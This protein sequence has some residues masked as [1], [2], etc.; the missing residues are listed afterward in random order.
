MAFRPL[1][2]GVTVNQQAESPVIPVETPKKTS[3][4]DTVLGAG[5][6]VGDFFTSS[7]QGLGKNIADIATAPQ[8]QSDAMRVAAADTSFLS[9]LI[10]LRRKASTEGK[11]TSHYDKLIADIHSDGYKAPDLPSA[12][13]VG[14]NAAGT[15]ADILSAGTYGAA[16]TAAM[17]TGELATKAVPTAVSLAEQGVKAGVD[18]AKSVG[19]TI[20][21]NNAK[22]GA[23]KVVEVLAL[24][25]ENMTLAQKKEAIDAGRQVV[26]NVAGGQKVT[27]A[28][29]PE[30]ERAGEILTDPK[31]WVNPVTAK[32]APH[33]IYAKVKAAIATLGSRAETYLAKNPVPIT[34]KEDFDLFRGLRDIA[35]KSSTD[36]ELK[37]YDEQI[38]LFEKQLVGR[39]GYNTSNYY[40][41]LKDWEQN[42]ASKLPRGK[43]ALL[44]P[45]GIA[46]A[47]IQ[48]ASDIRKAVRDLIASKH[49]EFKSR[50]YDLASLFEAKDS[51]LIN[52]AKTKSES[53]FKKH[54]LI[55]GGA[56]T[57]LAGTAGVGVLNAAKSIAD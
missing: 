50:M 36:T 45:T 11:D 33:I 39:G 15:A 38:K 28:A 1:E 44:D 2:A 56:A 37:A 5:K 21:E 54:P 51:A 13:D 46:S 12:L 14:L 31:L 34:N 18:A 55:T 8:Q 7:E 19:T 27:F 52:A 23:Q 10:D 4:V 29:T 16:K 40:K 26:K 24:P 57:A 20:A 32:D 42:I 48:A 47:K 22:K 41:A 35:S 9:T 17:K 6:A 43:E 3:I 30:V 53:F 25:A 49:P